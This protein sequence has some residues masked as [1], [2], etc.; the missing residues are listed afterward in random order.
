MHCTNNF[1]PNYQRSSHLASLMSN[2][3]S[4]SSDS[5][6]QT[7]MDPQRSPLLGAE[8][9]TERENSPIRFGFDEFNSFSKNSKTIQKC[10]IA[11]ICYVVLGVVLFSGFAKWTIIDSLYFTSVTI[12]TIGFGDLVPMCQTEMMY[13]GIF[14]VIGLLNHCFYSI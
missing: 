6:P 9:N 13:T 7:I 14:I 12:T 11:Y 2:Q 1:F 4:S 8:R 10:M 3:I 5:L